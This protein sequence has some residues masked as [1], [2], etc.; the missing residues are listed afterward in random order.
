MKGLWLSI[1][2]FFKKSRIE[3][4]LFISVALV[5]IC[6]LIVYFVFTGQYLQAVALI[7]PL[8][9]TVGVIVAID[10]L[11]T[12]EKNRHNDKER[13]ESRFRFDICL[14]QLEKLSS[15]LQPKS[16]SI[17]GGDSWV[18]NSGWN[19]EQLQ[20]A[21]LLIDSYSELR[22]GVLD[23]HL[24]ALGVEESIYKDALLTIVSGHSG[25]DYF[26][27]LDQ[28]CSSK[29]IEERLASHNQRLLE[30]AQEEDGKNFRYWD[31]HEYTKLPHSTPPMFLLKVIWFL[32]QKPEQ[33]VFGHNASIEEIVDALEEKGLSGIADYIFWYNK[34]ERKHDGALVLN[35]GAN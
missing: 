24:L 29:S 26:K 11:V 19:T 27:L 22:C 17:G 14:S 12:A 15:T 8:I 18:T 31:T 2:S 4:A 6:S 16:I 28:G 32:V 25:F 13:E 35:M 7:S 30:L 5:I 20:K 21:K 3:L 33:N 1:S 34:V 23:E 9:I 10:N